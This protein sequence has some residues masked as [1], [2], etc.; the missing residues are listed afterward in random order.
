MIHAIGDWVVDV[1][2][3]SIGNA[4][5]KCLKTTTDIG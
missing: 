3:D 1:A 4:L 5:K 2:L